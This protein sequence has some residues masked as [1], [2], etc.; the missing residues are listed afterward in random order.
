MILI[1]PLASSFLAVCP[2]VTVLYTKMRFKTSVCCTTELKLFFFRFSYTQNWISRERT[3]L[4]PE[5]NIK[6]IILNASSILTLKE[7]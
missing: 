3:Q 1:L 6:V 2:S 5:T 4:Q 7:N